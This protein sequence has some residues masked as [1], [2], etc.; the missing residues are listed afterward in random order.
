[1]RRI[2]KTNG[3]VCSLGQ[4]ED[5]ASLLLET[6]RRDTLRASPGSALETCRR[7]RRCRRISIPLK[8]IYDKD[9]VEMIARLTG[10]SGT[11]RVVWD[12]TQPNGESVG[13]SQAKEQLGFESRAV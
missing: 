11:L 13:T 8:R 6:A 7:C 4:V 3:R 9:L 5:T 2:R 12:T 1:M 10:F